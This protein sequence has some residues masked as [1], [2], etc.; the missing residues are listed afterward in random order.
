M[1][2]EIRGG[3]WKIRRVPV[4]TAVDSFQPPNAPTKYVQISNEGAENVRIYDS[5]ANADADTNYFVL[6]PNASGFEYFEGPL[7]LADE[8][9]KLWFKAEANTSTLAIVTYQR[10]G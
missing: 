7:E 3:Q 5:K 9:D 4:T 1:P 8:N 2:M 10:R 6:G